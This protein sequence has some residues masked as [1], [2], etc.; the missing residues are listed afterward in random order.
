MASDCDGCGA[1]CVA[2]FRDDYGYVDLDDRDVDRLT[3]REVRLCVV[4]EYAD[5]KMLKTR[6]RK[7]ATVCCFL[8]GTVLKT[9]RCAIYERRPDACRKFKPG[10]W[11]CRIAIRDAKGEDDE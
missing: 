4:Q 2:N 11:D 3:E 9:A 10:S 1:C 7:H 5:R 8:R 6:R